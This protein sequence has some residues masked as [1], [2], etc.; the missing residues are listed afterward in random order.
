MVV[1]LGT[2]ATIIALGATLAGVIVHL[3]SPRGLFDALTAHGL[4]PA[5][6]V[7]PVSIAVPVAETGLGLAGCA[8]LIL[9]MTTVKLAVMAAL[10]V[11]FAGYAGYLYRVA[12]TGRDVPCGCSLSREPVNGWTVTRAASFGIAALIA[13][14]TTPIVSAPTDVASWAVLAPAAATT[15]LLLWTLPAAM[16]QFDTRGVRWTS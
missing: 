14:A 15:L 3:R 4:L 2:W 10:A 16:R 9:G 8:A 1:F 11:L 6:L 13:A 12:S 5:S 7:R